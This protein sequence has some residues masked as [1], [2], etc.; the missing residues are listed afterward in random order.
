[1]TLSYYRRIRAMR[2]RTPA[3]TQEAID[4]ARKR[5]ERQRA[6]IALELKPVPEASILYDQDEP[7]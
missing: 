1:M 7:T 6:W 3:E 4:Q 5:I 2:R